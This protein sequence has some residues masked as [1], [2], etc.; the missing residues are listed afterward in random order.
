MPE[1]FK[2]KLFDHEVTP[3]PA[4]WETIAARLNDDTRHAL[5]ATKINQ[6]E[7]APPDSLW[8]AIT[9]NLDKAEA[10]TTTIKSSFFYRIAAAAA[11]IGIMAIGYWWIN[12]HGS[13][14]NLA[15]SIN[16][17][18]NPVKP[19]ETP[20]NEN[21]ATGSAINDTKDQAEAATG[22]TQSQHTNAAQV[23]A[24]DAGIL[25]Y[26]AISAVPSY[27]ERSIVINSAPIRDE[28][29]AIVHDMDL[30]TTNN[31]YMIIAGPDGQMTRIS[32]KFANVIRFLN[33]NGDDTEEYL[34]RV[35]K[36]GGL[37]KQRFKEW[38]QKIL[39]SHFIPSSSNFLDIMEFRELLD[40]K[41][42]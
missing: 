24:D 2:H 31:N 30:L 20:S 34:D 9:T 15:T 11:V 29:G 23:S 12:Q 28:S 3:P 32:S 35:I 5:L 18:L 14:Q 21:T 42:Q 26:A 36:E 17:N 27:S 4:A 22:G 25:R 7:V 41:Q 37:W 33:A 16:K 1:R 6:Y 13:K 10:N 19:P 40:E 38:R 8:S 39:D